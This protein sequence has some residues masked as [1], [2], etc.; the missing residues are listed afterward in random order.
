MREHGFSPTRIVLYTG[1]YGSE[2]TVFSHILHP[3]SCSGKA[4]DDIH[5]A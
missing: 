3:E 5:S 2:K 4:I 1:Q